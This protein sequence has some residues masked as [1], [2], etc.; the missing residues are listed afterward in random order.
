MM[1]Q[2]GA[3]EDDEDIA[4]D[5]G[6]QDYFVYYEW[7]E[8]GDIPEDVTHVRIHSSV[9]A[10]KNYAFYDRRQLRIVILNDELEEIGVWAF[11]SCESLEEIIIPNA[12]REIT[13]NAFGKCSGM[14]RVTLGDGLEEIGR[15][16][17]AYCESVEEIVVPPAVKTIKF[18]AFFNCTGLTRVTLGSGLE[19]IEGEAFENCTSI[20][21]ILIPPAVRVIDDAAFK[22]CSNLSNVEFCP[23]IEEFV[24]CDAMRDWWNQGVH[25]RCLATY[26]FMVRCGIP[27]RLGRVRV[28]SWRANL[29]S[30]LRRVPTIRAKGME[31]LFDSIDSRLS[32]YE[33]LEDLPALLELVI[34]K[35]II[36]DQSSPSNIPLTTEMKMQCRTDSISMVN[37]IVPNVMTFL[38]NGNDQDCMIDDLSEGEVE[39]EENDD[40]DNW[41]D[42]DDDNE[43]DDDQ[44]DEDDFDALNDDRENEYD[45]NQVSEDNEDEVKRRRVAE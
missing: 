11:S 35:S 28:H 7:M 36:T 29:Y 34:W 40:D 8:E 25:K 23:R 43:D 3:D 16:A 27:E 20:E 21:H 31:S 30:K 4:I 18:K 2:L 14:T 33:S 39:D 24:S 1:Q 45:D 12:V 17:F 44:A 10:I 22:G 9:R 26:C 42:E 19:E 41:G 6:L 15:Y 37:I 5:E 32:L 38:T 13:V